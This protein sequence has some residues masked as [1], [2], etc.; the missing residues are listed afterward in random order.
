[1]QL[2]DWFK[3]EGIPYQR[4]HRA[5]SKVAAQDWQEM[6]FKETKAIELL[7]LA[8]TFLSVEGQLNKIAHISDQ[9]ESDTEYNDIFGP[10]RLSA[11]RRF[12]I[13]CYKAGFRRRAFVNTIKDMG[14][15][16][17]YFLGSYQDLI[18]GLVCQA[19][20]NHSR[21]ETFAEDFG[22]DLALKHDFTNALCDLASTKIRPLLSGLLQDRAYAH[23]VRDQ[24]YS[25]LRSSDSFAKAMSA[26]K[27]QYGWDWIKLRS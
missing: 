10:H 9:F 26:A 20:L 2:E 25:F 22:H 8:R 6:D 4:Q 12:V 16:K 18:W 27:K 15:D 13:L 3:E 19:M 7:K 14:R 21:L 17:Y 23:L 5:F 1:L 24:N 11:D